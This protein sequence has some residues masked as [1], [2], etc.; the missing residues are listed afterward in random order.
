MG[1]RDARIVLALDT[2]TD[3]LCCAVG[4]VTDEIRLVAE[5][6][7]LCRRHANEELVDTCLG[8]L[9]EAGL[10]MADV[11]AVLVGRG[12]GSFTG[13]RIGIATAKGLACGLGKPLFGC[14]CLFFR[15]LNI[16]CTRLPQ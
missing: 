14:S 13:V 5:R 11:G 9:K 2:S 6:D 16:S 15:N 12:P 4:E 1:T 7:H 3:M 8:A 10:T